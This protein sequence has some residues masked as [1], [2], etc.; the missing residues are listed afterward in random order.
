MENH[1]IV[2]TKNL[3]E[4]FLLQ[5]YLQHDNPM[6]RSPVDNE[7]RV[8]GKDFWRAFDMP[9]ERKEICVSEYNMKNQYLHIEQLPE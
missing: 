6:G 3:W 7:P 5:Q 1:R 2:R 9:V 8:G 4:L